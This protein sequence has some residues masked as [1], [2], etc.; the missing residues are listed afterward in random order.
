MWTLLP[1]FIKINSIPPLRFKENTSME[2]KEFENIYKKLNIKTLSAFLYP[3]WYDDKFTKYLLWYD[4][5]GFINNIDMEP[6]SDSYISYF[7]NTI[8]WSNP[9][10][11]TISKE[12][13]IRFLLSYTNIKEVADSFLKIVNSYPTRIL[14]L[15]PKFD[16]WNLIYLLYFVLWWDKRYFVWDNKMR[17]SFIDGWVY[18]I[19]RKDFPIPQ[20]KKIKKNYTLSFLQNSNVLSRD[21]IIEINNITLKTVCNC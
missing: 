14:Y 18:L 4:L 16:K 20:N 6:L 11:K 10:T 13:F 12:S 2:M 5:D 9:F 19:F 3:K 15:D 21:K 17:V 1:S 7:M 8:F